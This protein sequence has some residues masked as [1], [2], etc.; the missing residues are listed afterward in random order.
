MIPLDTA[1]APEVI[2]RLGL[3]AG[4]GL[5]ALRHALRFRQPGVWGDSAT[6]PRSLILIREGDGQLEAFGA[7]E[8]EPAVGWL[9]ELGHRQAFTLHAPEAWLDAVHAR[10]GEVDQDEV[11][12]WSLLSRVPALTSG[13]AATRRLTLDDVGGFDA[14]APSWAL[15]GSGPSPA[16][17]E[18]AAAF[19]VPH[20]AG[21][22]ALA[23]VFDQADDHAALG[24]FTAPRYRRLGLGRAAAS[25]LG[26]HLVDRG[27]VPLWA[28]HG[29][30]DAS[31]ALARTLGFVLT[32]TEPLLRWP[33]R[34]DSP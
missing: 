32:V 10:V 21:F 24:L 17:I 18:H 12:T 6:T 8:P 13:P 15:R 9:V 33:P 22:A 29:R 2:H 11:E 3:P 30:N 19:G 7:G 5:L 28:T 14:L 34:V 26:S 1:A 16:L 23:W 25:A 4:P 20:G 27:R 31:R